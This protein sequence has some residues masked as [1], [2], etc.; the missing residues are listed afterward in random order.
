FYQCAGRGVTSPL[1]GKG[2]PTRPTIRVR[3]DHSASI[4][5]AA[6]VGDVGSGGG[7]NWNCWIRGI[8]PHRELGVPRQRV[9]DPPRDDPAHFASFTGCSRCSRTSRGREAKG[10]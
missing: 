6:S 10:I 9:C 8:S 7:G 5:G 4:R 2:G 3:S 1:V